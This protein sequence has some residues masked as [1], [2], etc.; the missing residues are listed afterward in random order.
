MELEIAKKIIEQRI[1]GHDTFVNKANKAER[2]YKKQNDILSEA[3]KE[4]D[5]EATIRTADNRVPSNFYKLLVNQKAAYMFSQ[6]PLFDTGDDEGSKKVLDVL[7]DSYAKNCKS[8]CVKASHAGIAWLHYWI[9]QKGSFQYGV[10]DS[11][12]VIPVWTSDLNREL[13]AVLRIYSEVD[14][15][16]GDEYILYEYWTDQECQAFRQKADLAIEEGL[17]S[18]YRFP[19]WAGGSL[20]DYSDTFKHDFGSVPFIPFLNNDETESDLTDIKELIDAYDKVYSGFVNDLED[21]QEIILTVTNYG[22]E[23][24]SLGELWNEIKQKKIIQLESEGADDR[25]GVSTLAIEI[26]VE[27][28]EKLLQMTRKSIFEQGQGIDPDP[29]NFGNSSGVALSYLYSLLELKAGM[30]ETEFR[31]SFA[32]FVRA[33]CQFLNI[34]ADTITQTWTRTSVSNDTELA[35]IAAQSKDVI[36]DETIVKNHPWVDNPTKELERLKA[37]RAEQTPEFDSIPKAAEVNG[38]DPLNGEDHDPKEQ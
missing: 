37:Q 6:P 9:D 19:V 27:A 7:G 13:S 32:K 3:K 34:Q 26:P 22:G 28:R 29:Q 14:E 25:S 21:I 20:S 36:S 18:Y 8:L 10:L 38:E 35:D 24:E 31:L 11:R 17:Q 23:A 15:K 1:R 33:I 2:Y 5:K 16:T 12:Q 4:P 30:V